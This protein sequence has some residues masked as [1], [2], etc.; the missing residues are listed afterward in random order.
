MKVNRN[1]AM[2]FEEIAALADQLSAIEKIRLV[3]HLAVGLGQQLEDE[4]PQSR[5][6]LRGIW[7]GVNVSAEDIDEARRE[8]WGGKQ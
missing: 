3:E 1:I 5:R 6:S 4:Q 8:M 7:A 2:S